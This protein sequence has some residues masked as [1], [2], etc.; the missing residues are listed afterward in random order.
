MAVNPALSLFDE[1]DVRLRR[2]ARLG[3]LFT[4]LLVVVVA[5]AGR[6]DPMALLA[7]GTPLAGDPL[8]G[9]ALRARAESLRPTLEEVLG[10]SLPLDRL[11]FRSLD[12]EQQIAETLHKRRATP[13]RA[14]WTHEGHLKR[15]A[16]LRRGLG[17]RVGEYDSAALSVLVYRD[18]LDVTT[19][20]AGST[21]VACS[22]RSS[23]TSSCT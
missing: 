3:S 1:E 8:S 15:V 17:M 2:L 18:T 12:I 14:S 10:S 20:A 13:L 23:C 4:L 7:E 21:R 6:S 19:C 16:E 22:T 9:A 5:A 11:T